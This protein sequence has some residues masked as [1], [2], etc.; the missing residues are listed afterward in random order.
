M[1][2][3][4]LA[5]GWQQTWYV[6]LCPQGVLIL[7]E[8][9][10]NYTQCLHILGTQTKLTHFRI[11]CYTIVLLCFCSRVKLANLESQGSVV[12]LALRW[13]FS[14]RFWFILTVSI[15]NSLVKKTP[16]YTVG[17]NNVILLGE[18]NQLS[19][20]KWDSNVNI[21]VVISEIADWYLRE[22]IYS[23]LQNIYFIA[24]LSVKIVLS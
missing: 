11:S 16:W 17:L 15:L 21:Q 19:K 3:L 1:P 24:L 7:S 23:S 6:I 12:L 18:E 10:K 22:N 5:T 9:I 13:V 20:K 14:G 4:A 8:T 2:L